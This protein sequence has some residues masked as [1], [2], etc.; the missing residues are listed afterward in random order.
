MDRSVDE[1]EE[2]QGRCSTPHEQW[3]TKKRGHRRRVNTEK[4]GQ[5]MDSRRFERDRRERIGRRDGDEQRGGARREC[6]DGRGTE[7][8]TRLSA[9]GVFGNRPTRA[10]I[11]EKTS[12]LFCARE[13][14]GREKSKR[15]T[16][17]IALLANIRKS[18]TVAIC[19]R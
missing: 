8:V 4:S 15:E 13:S 2:V 19:C 18:C 5:K 10:L 9:L 12:Q 17:C 3:G 16:A 14:R 7:K 6:A 11:L 1:Q